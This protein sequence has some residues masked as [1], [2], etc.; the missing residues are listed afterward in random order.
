MLEIVRNEIAPRCRRALIVTHS[1]SDRGLGA[2][3]LRAGTEVWLLLDD[4]L[5]R[6]PRN[7]V[8][9]W[10]GT[11]RMHVRSG[12]DLPGEKGGVC[13][14]GKVFLFESDLESGP[15]W[16][17]FVGS[18]NLTARAFAP[19]DGAPTAGEWKNEEWFL[20]A[21]GPAGSPPMQEARREIQRLWE[22][23]GSR[24]LP[25]PL[26]HT[27]PVVFLP[28]DRPVPAR[29][30]GLLERI[31]RYEIARPW[32]VQE[33]AI[34]RAEEILLDDEGPPCLVVMPPGSG[35]TLVA[36]EVFYRVAAQLADGPVTCAWVCPSET[37][38]YQTIGTLRACPTHRSAGAGDRIL[39]YRSG[40][41]YDGVTG[42]ESY[43]NVGSGSSLVVVSNVDQFASSHGMAELK[44]LREGS[45]G[46]DVLVVD[47]AHHSS[48][49]TWDAV[50][51][52][53]AGRGR[54]F[55]RRTR[56]LGLTATPWRMLGGDW[57]FN[58]HPEGVVEVPLDACDEILSH[59]TWRVLEASG[60]RH[61][62]KTASTLRGDQ[63]VAYE[64]LEEVAGDRERNR[65]ILDEIERLATACGLEKILV[66]AATTSHC[67]LLAD[68]LR[69]RPALQAIPLTVLHSHDGRTAAERAE[70]VRRFRSAPDRAILVNLEMLIEGYDVADLDAVIL[71]RPTMSHG[72]FYQMVGRAM[73]GAGG[74]RRPMIIDVP[75]RF[76]GPTANLIVGIDT[77]DPP[78]ARGW[79]DPGV[80]ERLQ[81]AVDLRGYIRR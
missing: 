18:G 39:L 72:Y 61:R 74:G 30:E 77:W 53:F 64:T 8:V 19:G 41:F 79:R 31:P 16:E 40:R 52:G 54:N 4:L 48:A 2:L 38:A 42:D 67:D 75:T 57:R 1:C 65:R 29:P 66:Y 71:A 69:G 63:D 7:D 50:I 56:V 47:E 81:E 3:A 35:K 46:F 22:R 59:P 23:G 21:R 33:G 6:P 44:R 17:L 36:A 5:A 25:L 51:G 20:H 60:R 11:P 55:A 70:A 73:R 32:K 15:E 14:H 13:Q 24:V 62:A 43:A 28:L 45:G 68:G 10:L 12:S 80:A 37:V 49:P 34:A 58:E 27:A 78:I 26:A 76:E 9:R